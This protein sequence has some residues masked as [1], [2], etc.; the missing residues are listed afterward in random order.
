MRA[1]VAETGD[2]GGKEETEGVQR[3]EIPHASDGVRVQFP[4]SQGGHNVSLIVLGA[5]LAQLVFV[6]AHLN[7]CDL[8]GIQET[9]GLGL[10]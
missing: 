6:E 4:V 8:F 1:R 10:Q 7:T 9:S 3:H 5:V 2:D